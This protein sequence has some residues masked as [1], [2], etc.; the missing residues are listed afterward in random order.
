MCPRRFC[1]INTSF[2]D[3]LFPGTA[4]AAVR[5]RG[6]CNAYSKVSSH[7]QLNDVLQ[8]GSFQFSGFLFFA[9]G[10]RTAYSVLTNIL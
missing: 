7:G 3:L 2:R 4:V 9:V 6:N 10:V 8:L 1:R 5:R